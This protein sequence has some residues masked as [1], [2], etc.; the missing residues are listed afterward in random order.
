MFSSIMHKSDSVKAMFSMQF[1]HKKRMP[2]TRTEKKFALAFYYS[3][4]ASYKLFKRNGFVLPALSTIRGWIGESRFFPGTD[5]KFAQQLKLK[6]ESMERI[7]KQCVL[8]FDEVDLMAKLEYSKPYDFIE[9]FEDVGHLGRTKVVAKKALVFMTRGLFSKWKLPFAYYLSGSGI[10]KE[11]LHVLIKY[12]IEELQKCGLVVRA[13]V[14]DQATTNVAA[15]KLLGVTEDKPYIDTYEQKIIFIYDAPHLFKNFRNNLLDGDYQVDV[16][17]KKRLIKYNDIART[18]ELD[19]MGKARAMVKLTDAHISPNSFQKQSCKLA[20][21]V[22]SHTVSAA[23]KTCTET[24]QLKSES[25][26]DTANF[27]SLMNNTFDNL[28]SKI[29]YDKNPYI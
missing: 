11:Q 13:A 16:H 29:K 2:W 23:I 18:Y 9:G 17:G 26:I 10:K 28:N 8:A 5:K 27:I 7:E 15:L 6:T 21:Q 1:L 19:K 25:A 14:C 20:L 22:F 3:S 24:G 4:P 12:T